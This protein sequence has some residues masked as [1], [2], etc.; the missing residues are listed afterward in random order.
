ML[1]T[2]TFLLYWMIAQQLQGGNQQGRVPATVAQ[3]ISDYPLFDPILPIINYA[4]GMFTPAVLLHLIALGCGYYVASEFVIELVRSL[5]NLPDEDQAQELFTR[6]R[7]PPSPLSKPVPLNH[8]NFLQMQAEEPLLSIGGPGYVAISEGDVAVTEVNGRF[9]RVIGFGKKKLRRFERIVN[10]LSL[11]EQESRQTEI[12]LMTQE[13]FPLYTDIH[14]R[15]RIKRRPAVRGERAGYAIDDDS[16]RQAAYSQ[17]VTNYSVTR[18]TSIPMM[19]AIS[20]LTTILAQKHLEQLIDPRV[21]ASI[22]PQPAIQHTLKEK[23]AQ[24][25]DELGVELIDVRHTGLKMND[26][27]QATMLEYW[28]KYNKPLS[29]V[30]A[31]PS[32]ADDA[33]NR[34]REKMIQG[35]ASTSDMVRMP[36]MM[37]A[38]RTDSHTEQKMLQMLEMMQLMLDQG[39]IQQHENLLIL[40]R[41]RVNHLIWQLID[42][43]RDTLRYSS[44]LTAESLNMLIKSPRLLLRM[45]ETVTFQAKPAVR[46][47]LASADYSLEASKQIEVERGMS[48]YDTL[49]VRQNEL[50][51]LTQ[52]LLKE[53]S[54]AAAEELNL[55]AEGA[56]QLAQSAELSDRFAKTVT[57]YFL[58]PP[59]DSASDDRTLP[60]TSTK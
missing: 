37:P 20:I 58:P 31:T 9:E 46:S 4:A 57:Q 45:R 24:E 5:Y 48:E 21:Q 15:F 17:I 43:M 27:L 38:P 16:I 23:L 42:E 39:Q 51:V 60:Q 28:Q 7:V 35:L 50:G 8:R 55:T 53:A 52:Q 12:E 26:K 19:R 29:G 10:V 22:A 13:G 1:A 41:N 44:T 3:L 49:V 32:G 59:S 18:W 6:L 30:D 33:M 40:Q 14:L 2:F 54:M 34:A 25:L 56:A 36:S 11:Y 47:A